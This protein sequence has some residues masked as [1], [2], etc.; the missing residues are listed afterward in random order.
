[1]LVNP[2]E[3]CDLGYEVRWGVYIYFSG[4]R[5][6]LEVSDASDDCGAYRFTNFTIPSDGSEV[7]LRK[8]GIVVISDVSILGSIP[9]DCSFQLCKGCTD[10]ISS[11]SRHMKLSMFAFTTPGVIRHPSWS[12][13]LCMCVCLCVSV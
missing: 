12:R 2:G 8:V 3:L 5:H 10:Y 9:Q 1:M 6:D 7:G 11:V 4:L 13:L